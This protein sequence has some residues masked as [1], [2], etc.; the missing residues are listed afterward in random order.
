M[1]TNAFIIYFSLLKGEVTVKF[2]ELVWNFKD[3]GKQTNKI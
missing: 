2:K 1:R 3:E